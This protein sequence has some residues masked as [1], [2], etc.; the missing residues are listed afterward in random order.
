MSEHPKVIPIKPEEV[1]LYAFVY[2]R[3]QSGME[4]IDMDS[5]I[6]IC[7]TCG[8]PSDNVAKAVLAKTVKSGTLQFR[9]EGDVYYYAPKL[10]AGD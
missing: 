8:C 5:L 4:E 7:I 2:F 9:K 1:I 6:R 3:Q 10:P